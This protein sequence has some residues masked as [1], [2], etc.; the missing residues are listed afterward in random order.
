MPCEYRTIIEGHG[1]VLQLGDD[2]DV[3]DLK[4]TAGK[5]IKQTSALHFKIKERRRFFIRRH[6]NGRNIEVHGELVYKHNVGEYKTITRKQHHLRNVK[7]Y[8]IQK[9]EQPRV[10]EEKAT[11]VKKLLTK[12]FGLDW[13]K[14]AENLQYYINFFDRQV[15][16]HDQCWE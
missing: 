5:I 14:S 1:K 6:K 10:K 12:H 7:P 15:S 13:E 8:I 3:Y 2:V 11:D 4:E 9:Y 16:T